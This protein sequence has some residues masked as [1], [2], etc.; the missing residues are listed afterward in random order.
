MLPGSSLQK[1]NV[2]KRLKPI[3]ALALGSSGCVYVPLG[4]IPK[5]DVTSLASGT[6]SVTF[7]ATVR[8]G[9][10]RTQTVITPWTR[11]NIHHVVIQVLKLDGTAEKFVFRTAETP[12]DI[13]ITSE[14]LEKDFP[15]DKLAPNTTYRLRARAYSE[16]EASDAALISDD[17]ASFVDVVVKN[18]D[19][20]VAAN[21]PIKLRDKLFAGETSSELHGIFDGLLRYNEERIELEDNPPALQG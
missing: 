15:I 1:E 21:L 16:P 18:D 12:Y 17:E 11:E 8:D 9:G 3:L 20:P 5:L 10:Y 19:R 2:S 7:R 13:T 6:R 4:S 14:D